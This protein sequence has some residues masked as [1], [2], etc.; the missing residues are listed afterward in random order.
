MKKIL[1]VL[2]IGLI[3]TAITACSP[4]VQTIEYYTQ[5]KPEMEEMLKKCNNMSIDEVQKDA[6]CTNAQ[7]AATQLMFEGLSKM[8]PNL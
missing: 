3:E 8:K 5:H 7:K 4:K 1:L 6:N 2:C